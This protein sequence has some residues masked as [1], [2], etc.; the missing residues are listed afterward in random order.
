MAKL[1]IGSQ[2]LILP[3]IFAIG[4]RTA[5]NPEMKAQDTLRLVSRGLEQYYLNH[6]HYPEFS[7][8]EAM[9][10]SN[11]VIVKENLI[12]SDIPTKDPW[13]QS[14]EGRSVKQMYK[15]TCFGDPKISEGAMFSR[16]PG[17]T[18]GPAGPL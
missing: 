6:G 13:G 17:R 15:L 2:I 16:E 5:P 1:E 11:S 12:P 7:S 4:C 14:Y 18:T 8:F 10:N 9:V 3:V